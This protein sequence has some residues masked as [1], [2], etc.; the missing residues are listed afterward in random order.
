L[1]PTK[2]TLSDSLKDRWT[3]N[4][5]TEGVLAYIVNTLTSPES[6]GIS[7]IERAYR[8]C[9]YRNQRNAEVWAAGSAFL[10]KRFKNKSVYF[11]VDCPDEG[12]VTFH[13]A[14][15]DSPRDVHSTPQ[16]HRS[17]NVNLLKPKDE[18]IIP[19]IE[20]LPRAAP[21]TQQ[22]Q[23]AKPAYKRTFKT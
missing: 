20:I 9:D 23:G 18:W 11:A 8:N 10:Q 3:A 13:L 15:A 5:E 17:W 1:L 21:K 7:M 22:V 6:D 19:P 12:H 2:A 4:P 16:A 14:I